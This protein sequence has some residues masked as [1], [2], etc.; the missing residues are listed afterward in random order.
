MRQKLNS[1]PMTFYANCNIP[2]NTKFT[3]VTAGKGLSGTLHNVKNGATVEAF[4]DG[5]PTCSGKAA[6]PDLKIAYDIKH[7]T[8]TATTVK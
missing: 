6:A 4:S 8:V 2:L 3:V 7:G 5:S 1:V